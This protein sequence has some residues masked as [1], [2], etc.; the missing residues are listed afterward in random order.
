M[1][2]LQGS[3]SQSYNWIL[4]ALTYRSLRSGIVLKNFLI[5]YILMGFIWMIFQGFLVY[6]RRLTFFG[7]TENNS[8]VTRA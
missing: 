7:Y 3:L 8:L 1:N 5:I 2:P 4:T 6:E